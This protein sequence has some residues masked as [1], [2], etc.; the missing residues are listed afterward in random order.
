VTRF[1]ADAALLTAAFLWGGAFVAQRL[2]EGVVPPVGFVAARFAISALLLAPLAAIET[3][4]AAVRFDAPAWRQAP[5]PWKPA[6]RAAQAVR[7]RA[8]AARAGRAQARSGGRAGCPWRTE[9]L[10][11]AWRPAATTGTAQPRRRSC[12]G[13]VYR[14]RAPVVFERGPANA[15]TRQHPPPQRRARSLQQDARYLMVAH[16]DAENITRKRY[17]RGT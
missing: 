12:P 14:S 4:R 5:E 8:G 16:P 13:D 17:R 7:S 9:R 11:W 1:R 15:E 10:R 2:A 6:A 3:R